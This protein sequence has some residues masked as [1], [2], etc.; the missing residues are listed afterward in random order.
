[1]KVIKYTAHCEIEL[2]ERRSYSRS[3]KMAQ[4]EVGIEEGICVSR[5][6][7]WVGLLEI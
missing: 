4:P 7:F 3:A 1:M 2:H 6:I 5:R